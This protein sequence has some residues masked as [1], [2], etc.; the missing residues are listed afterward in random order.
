[1]NCKKENLN[2]LF[3]VKRNWTCMSNLKSSFWIKCTYG[4]RVDGEIIMQS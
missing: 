1:M 4:Y 3:N 2:I